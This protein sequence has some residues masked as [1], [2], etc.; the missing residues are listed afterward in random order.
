MVAAMVGTAAAVI[1]G[2]RLFR[3]R[4]ELQAIKEQPQTAS[5]PPNP[6]FHPIEVEDQKLM[7]RWFIR[8]PPHEW[9]LWR[10][11]A[12]NLSPQEVQQALDGPFHAAPGCNAPLLEF[13]GHG[14]GELLPPTLAEQCRHCGERVFQGYAGVSRVRADAL[15]ELQ[16]MNLNGTALEGRTLQ[17]PPIVLE[18][19][20]YWHV[21]RR[22]DPYD[23]QFKP[24]TKAPWPDCRRLMPCTP[25]AHRS[26]PSS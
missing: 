18:K 9:L 23:S 26:Y 25:R 1:L 6:L 14:V 19:P 16:P 21:Q 20:A 4:R 13:H 22:G 12:K 17:D 7:L 11:V 10:N 5:S 24:A 15:E 2:I 3:V 8:R